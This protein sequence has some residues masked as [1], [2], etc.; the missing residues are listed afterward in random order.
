MK[1]I[2]N[3]TVILIL[4]VISYSCFWYLILLSNYNNLND[5]VFDLGVSLQRAW[6]YLHVKISFKI[7]INLLSEGPIVSIFSPLADTQFFPIWLGILDFFTFSP[8]IF[9]YYLTE[10]K[11]HNAT[12]SFATAAIYLFSFLLPGLVYVDFHYQVLFVFFFIGGYYFYTH[13]N[14]KFS[15]VFFSLSAM[16]KYPFGVFVLMFSLVELL[17][18]KNLDRSNHIHIDQIII[19]LC[20]FII[21]SL[22]LILGFLFIKNPI[23]NNTPVTFNIQSILNT[24]L[25]GFLTLLIFLA[26]FAFIPLISKKFL[27]YLLIL[28]II[29]IIYGGYYAY[30]NILYFHH[31]APWITFLILGFIDSLQLINLRESSRSKKNAKTNR[32]LFHYK[33]S[34]V[35]VFIISATLLTAGFGI[36]YQ[37]FS[38]LNHISNQNFGFTNL[39]LKSSQALSQM[40]SL[41]HFVPENSTLLVQDNM[42]FMFPRDIGNP[43]SIPMVAGINFGNFDNYSLSNNSFPFLNYNTTIC[44]VM[45]DSSTAD[46]FNHN[47]GIP[48]MAN[49]VTIFLHSKLYGVYAISGPA[50]LL[51]RSY[52]GHPIIISQ[53]KELLKP[54]SFSSS[55][56]ILSNGTLLMNSTLYNTSYSLLNY[57]VLPGQ[58]SANFYINET[59]VIGNQ[60]IYTDLLN[61]NGSLI[62]CYHRFNI[63]TT[64]HPYIFRLKFNFSVQSPGY[65]WLKVFLNNGRIGDTYIGPILISLS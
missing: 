26:P 33:Y 22:T 60:A 10:T 35:K 65:Y 63:T 43:Y 32:Y 2:K 37:P 50:F 11:L 21:S 25:S 53:F 4:F 47:E 13:G 28:T 9:I 8:A 29:S 16:V 38:E 20:I 12:Y 52:T 30:P 41:S 62:L 49:I 39:E 14:N 31:T 17:S 61:G 51:K 27:P 57:F 46:F 1:Q 6:T 36:V 44:W 59:G 48:S 5:G 18:K 34:K 15:L 19:L 56:N 45:A 42:Y 55:G 7:F 40:E 58:Y 3:E 54:S 64:D 23:S 24:S